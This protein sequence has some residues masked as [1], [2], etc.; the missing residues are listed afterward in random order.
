MHPS[1]AFT[2][3]LTMSDSKMTVPKFGS[4]RPKPAHLPEK[5]VDEKERVDKTRDVVKHSKRHRSRSRSRD[6]ERHRHS[7]KPRQQE[8]RPETVIKRA[9]VSEGELFVVDRKG[10]EKNLIYGSIHRYDVPQFR[11]IGNGNVL[12]IS[13][14]MKIDRDA[15]DEKKIFLRDTRDSD[16]KRRERYT[17][18]RMDKPRLLRIRPDAQLDEINQASG[19]ISLE[20]LRRGKKR[21]RS[22]SQA[23]D[24]DS[25]NE[26]D[27][28][29]IHGKEKA[30]AN[31]P[32]DEAFEYASES[33]GSD[34][35]GGQSNMTDARRKNV[36]L[37][38]AVELSP[39]DLKAWLTLIQHQDLLLRGDDERRRVTNAEIKS[40]A[41]IKIHSKCIAH[42]IPKWHYVVVA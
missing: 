31:K 25:N 37:S 3:L 38:R 7:D 22:G 34:S 5:T 24:S 35:G 19:F 20:P 18:L 32:Q 10:D 29:S 6:R 30:K 13:R 26:R 11:R 39:H 1:N 8:S 27:Y 42:R 21:K 40:T 16:I 36:E 15:S 14:N 2:D 23:S 4:F 33:E 12:G 17:F 41:D 9:E 28:R